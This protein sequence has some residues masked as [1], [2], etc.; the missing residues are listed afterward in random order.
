MHIARRIFALLL[1]LTVFL[2]PTAAASILPQATGSHI[3]W[4]DRFQKPSPDYA[5]VFYRWLESN[6]DADGA[7]A[8]P[9]RA[10]EIRAGTYG[11]LL[12][13]F[14]GTASFR[15]DTG[16]DEAAA[17]R[18]AVIAAV[19][20]KHAD[21]INE[22]YEYARAVY[23]AFDHDHSEVFWLSGHTVCAEFYGFSWRYA[24]GYGTV[25]YTKRVYFYL[26]NDETGFDIRE[27]EYRSPAIIAERIADRDADAA[28]ILNSAEVRNAATRYEQIKALNR[29]LTYRNAYNTG[30][31]LD[32]DVIGPEPRNCLGALN[33]RTG[34]VG[35]VCEGYARAFKL[36]CDRLNIPCVLITGTSYPSG[37]RHMWNCVQ[38]D[39]G[40]WYGVDVTWNDPKSSKSGAA[41]SGSE[42]EN[43]L[44]VGSDTFITSR[45]FG[46]S[47]ILK[48]DGLD[49]DFVFSNSPTLSAVRYDPANALPLK[50]SVGDVIGHVLHTDIV[51]FID[52]H[53]IR[54]YNIGGN[55]W[56]VAEDLL[57]YGFEVTWLGDERRLVIGTRRTAA[58]DAYQP[59]PGTASSGVSGMPAMPYYFTDI[60]VTLAGRPVEG[61]NIGGFTCIGMDDLASAFAVNYVWNPDARTLSMATQN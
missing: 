22:A 56:I 53:P 13:S 15:Y 4:F 44:L 26:R 55:T 29:A 21:E 14:F 38:M 11:Y 52:G 12:R 36:L 57:N 39:D 2:L 8:D 10:E 37:E 31:N 51:C 58:P 43:Y 33:G 47:H 50:P 49:T 42:T 1:C 20:S 18:E 41:R 19:K 30:T 35:P 27:P 61:V 32:P 23:Q 60:T 45:T 5:T 3:L 6:A 7:L 9:T 54:S 48:N 40:Q 17:A 34:S 24:N 16:G 25:E 59:V 28:S 46:T